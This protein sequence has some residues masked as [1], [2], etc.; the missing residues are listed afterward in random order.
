VEHDYRSAVARFLVTP[1]LARGADVVLDQDAAH[2]MRVL[3]LK[4]GV[5]VGLTDGRGL[6]GLGT[7]TRLGQLAPRTLAP[8]DQRV[9]V[10]DESRISSQGARTVGR[11]PHPVRRRVAP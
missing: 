8:I 7:L 2:H 10:S 5:R 3:R 4:P 6:T 9:A 11:R 1:P